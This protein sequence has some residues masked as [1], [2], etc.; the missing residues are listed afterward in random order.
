MLTLLDKRAR[1]NAYMKAYVKRRC[2]SDPVFHEKLKSKSREY[3]SRWALT[4]Q[5]EKKA[6]N[7]L[8]KGQYNHEYRLKRHAA[9]LVKERAYRQEHPE[10][11]LKAKHKYRATEKYRRWQK[12][13]NRRPLVRLANKAKNHSRRVAGCPELLNKATLQRL[14]EDNIKF[15]GT[16]TC[17]L[18]RQAIPFGQD[19][20]EHKLPV[21][22]GGT[23]AYSNLGIAHR[24]C[25]FKKKNKTVQEYEDYIKRRASWQI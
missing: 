8:R 3:A 14:Y 22:R 5:E 13:Y 20:I 18:C 9:A 17:V 6:A 19:T 4:H 2:A 10:I 23:N 24:S 7:A 16:L 11:H 12:E 1:H 15:Y 21:S 25:N